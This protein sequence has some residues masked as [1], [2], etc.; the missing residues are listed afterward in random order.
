MEQGRRMGDAGRM[1]IR[2][3]TEWVVEA[4]SLGVLAYVQPLERVPGRRMA[5]GRAQDGG[6]PSNHFVAEALAAAV[7][8]H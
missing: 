5:G 7:V 8:G 1:N 2:A 6:L 3:R 4:S